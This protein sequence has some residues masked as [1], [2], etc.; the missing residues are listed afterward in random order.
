MSVFIVSK[1]PALS[2][3]VKISGAKNSVLP[4][5]AGC[6]LTEEECIISSVP[7][8]N[9]VMV[10][11]DILKK[12]GATV[13]YDVKKE[14]ISVCCKDIVSFEEE[15]E[16]AGKLRAS[17]IVMGALIG[18]IGKA[19]IPMP[20]GCPIGSRPV[21]LHLKGFQSM[22]VSI[23][24]EKGFVF[25]DGSSIC[26]GKVYLDFPSVGAT[27]NIMLASALLEDTTVIENAS[28]EPEIC[29]LAKF[30]SKM[31]VKIQG[32]GTDTIKIQGAKKLSG[33]KHKVMPDRIEAGTFMVASAITGGDIILENVIAEHLK[34][35]TAKLCESNVCVEDLGGNKIRVFVKDKLKP[36]NIKTMPFPGFPTD[37]QAQFMSLLAVISGTSTI[38]ETIFENRFI[39]AGE[40]VRMGADIR[41]D[42][43]SAVIEGV[44]KLTGAEVRA[45]DLRGGAGLILLGLVSEGETRISDIYNIERGY[46]N[47]EEKLKGLGALIERVD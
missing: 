12:L 40:M 16:D 29:D 31:G 30:L 8:L 19:K 39:H 17:F 23:E 2:G 6:I 36:V 35:V 26:G 28:A 43:R 42:S 32:A 45:T 7:P 14:K 24:Q 25:A 38:T 1:S 27:E 37:M 47:I 4:I 33:V 3:S 22:G 11:I 15:S 5:L 46:Y 44:E 21:D 13:N 34:P 18:R 10:M 41:I 9:D 20:G